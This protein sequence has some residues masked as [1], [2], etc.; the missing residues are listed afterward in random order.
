[1]KIGFL[2]I[3]SEVLD[4]KI[5]DQNTKIL[6]DFLRGHHLEINESIVVRDHEKAI[7][8]AVKQLLK[9]NDVIITS[10]GL[11]PTKDDI[12]KL[13]LA[14]YLGR[15]IL[16]S[17]DAVKI[18]IQNYHRLG[19]VFPEND[20]AYSYLPENFIPLPNSTGFAP[21]FYTRIEESTLLSAP[22]VPREFKSMM[23]DHLLNV[24]SEKLDHHIIL[25]HFIARTKNVPEEKIFGEVDPQLWQKLEQYGEVSSLPILMGV[26]IGIK[27]RASHQDEMNQKIHD[28]TLIF[29][30]SPLI[31]NIWH[32]GPESIEQRIV[33]IAN[34]RKI[35]FGFAES[36]TGGLCSHRIT[37]ISG[38]STSFMGSMIS[39]DEGLKNLILGVS[40]ESLDQFSAV[41]SQVADEM[42]KGLLQK[43]NL[44]IAISITGYAGPLGGSDQLPIGS[45]FIG[46]ATRGQSVT[47][48]YLL[49]KGD[50]EIL[51]QRFS[52]A[53]L[54][55]LLEEIENFA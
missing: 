18:S 13:T 20:H 33:Q 2:I 17:D 39:Y 29:K 35:K 15:K 50:R 44:D 32:F 30:S 52:Q 7:E 41:S 48:E 54:Y 45:V 31:K 34:H 5:A 53:A 14:R 3:G 46:R 12:T 1:M 23:A 11:G 27:I 43:F 16:F 9:S 26:D 42:A 47:S 10:G 4:G 36:V 24:I 37:N 40:N 38:C 19:R 49:L 21:G 51:K 6:A 28:I 25:H 8:S 22:G 55:A